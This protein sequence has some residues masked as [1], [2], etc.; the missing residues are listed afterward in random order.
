MADTQSERAEE[1]RAELVKTLLEKIN[2]DT[3]PST[4]MLDLL[5]ELLTDDE[6]PEYVM[7]LQQRLAADRYPSIPLMDRLVQIAKP[8]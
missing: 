8:A 5:E 4:T 6:L 1:V 3:Y 2:G 7:F